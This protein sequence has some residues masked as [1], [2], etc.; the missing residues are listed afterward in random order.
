MGIVNCPNCGKSFLSPR[1]EDGGKKVCS[2]CETSLQSRLNEIDREYTMKDKD[3][4]SEA[5]YREKMEKM[6]NEKVN[7]VEFA[8]SDIPPEYLSPTLAQMAEEIIDPEIRDR[9]FCIGTLDEIQLG[10]N[11]VEL[12]S[13]YDPK[14]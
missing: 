6:Q 14:E 1:E 12:R 2:D 7:K 4:L 8:L 11:G 10:E 13:Y 5:E 9:S 3:D